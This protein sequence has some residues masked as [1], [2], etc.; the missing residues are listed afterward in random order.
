MD[1]VGGLNVIPRRSRAA[2]NS[3]TH[4]FILKK[5]GPFLAPFAEHTH[6]NGRYT[7]H[8]VPTPSPEKHTCENTNKGRAGGPR[9]RSWRERAL[10]PCDQDSDFNEIEKAF[11]GQAQL[12]LGRP[13]RFRLSRAPLVSRPDSPFDFPHPIPLYSSVIVPLLTSVPRPT[14]QET[15]AHP[16]RVVTSV[17][18]LNA[19][20]CCAAGGRQQI[21]ARKLIS[22]ISLR[23]LGVVKYHV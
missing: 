10:E 4:Q 5:L 14:L 18:S 19:P 1:H 13:G 21:S 17:A 6:K 20:P 7:L 8:A 15:A 9:E 16:L 3:P 12:T 23:K 11:W 22:E 2:T